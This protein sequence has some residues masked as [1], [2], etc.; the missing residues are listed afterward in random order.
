MICGVPEK[1]GFPVH[2]VALAIARELSR[3]ADRTH[4]HRC[5]GIGVCSI[6]ICEYYYGKAGI[7]EHIAFCCEAIDRPVVPN[8]RVVIESAKRQSKAIRPAPWDQGAYRGCHGR[9]G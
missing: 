3:G 1:S 7:K 9:E 2:Q 8:G 5:D 6:R 4:D